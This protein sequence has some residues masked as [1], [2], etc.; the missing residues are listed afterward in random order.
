MI[1]TLTEAMEMAH[2]DSA[3]RAHQLQCATRTH[4]DVLKELGSLAYQARQKLLN[5]HHEYDRMDRGTS[6]DLACLMRCLCDEL[7]LL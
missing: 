1:P 7:E 2:Q 5:R 3:E 4:A 6:R